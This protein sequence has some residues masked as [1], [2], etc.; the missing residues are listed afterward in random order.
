[1]AQPQAVEHA[2]G[3][4]LD[5][6]IE[7]AKNLVGLDFATTTQ[8]HLTSTTF[9]TIR[10]FAESYGDPNPLY[11]DESYG[12]STRWGTQIAPPLIGV[13]VNKPLLGD[14]R[15]P[16]HKR[17]S[18]R[19]IH[20]F[21]SGSSWDLY[22]PVVPGDTLYQFEGYEDVEVK[23]SEFAGRSVIITRRHVRMN[24]DAEVVS[25]SRMIA[26]H[27]ER[28]ASKENGK[29]NGLEFT[30]YTPKDIAAIDEIYASERPRGPQKR[31]FEEVRV[32]DKLGPMAKGPLTITD[33][34]VFHAGGYGFTPYKIC[35]GRIAYENR[36]RIGPFYVPNAQGVPDVA[37]R[38][39]WDEAWA[40]DVGVPRPY[41]YGILRDCW[42]THLLT[43]WMGDDGWLVSYSSQMRKF[44]YMG[45]YHLL[46]GEVVGKRERDGNFL[47][48]VELRGTNQRDEATCPATATIAL[49]S[50][51]GGD[52][53]LPQ[54]PSDIARRARQMMD[55]HHELLAQEAER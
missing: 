31:Y 42:L 1:M 14:P 53:R 32:G 13:A 29:Y 43:D 2:A 22:R 35:T 21:V 17:P 48:D 46:T 7:R 34:V 44:N 45:D 12:R 40:Q 50:K 37:Q 41:D 33:I 24:Q 49:P 8:E 52:I 55:R 47:V 4:F 6:D 23:E 20:V 15:G 10:N 3:T 30:N 18:F 19:G 54:V 26:I 51:S 11:T 5:R 16:E 27:V 9:D 25:V 36:M 38:V 39:H 28:K